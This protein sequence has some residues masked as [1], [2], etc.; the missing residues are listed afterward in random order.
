MKVLFGGNSFIM[1][2]S[3]IEDSCEHEYIS[4]KEWHIV[5][6]ESVPHL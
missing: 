3:H 6:I 2:H 4:F 5:T 1:T